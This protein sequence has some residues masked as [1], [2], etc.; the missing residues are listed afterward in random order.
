[1]DEQWSF[2]G[3]KKNQR[4]LWYA[5]ELRFKRIIAHA[6]GRRTDATLKNL[7][8]PYR[9]KF[10]CTDQWPSYAKYLPEEPHIIGKRFT[11]RIERKNLNF[12]TFEAVMPS[13]YLLFKVRR[14]S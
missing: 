13:I 5:W 2:V 12:R 10:Y 9:F 3:S 11:Q 1:M 8:K 6:F 7:L 4:W 14:S